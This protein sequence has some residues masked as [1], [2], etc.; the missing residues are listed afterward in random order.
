MITKYRY[1]SRVIAY[2]SHPLNDGMVREVLSGE[3]YPLS[4]LK[5]YCPTV[6]VDIGSNVG[7]SLIYFHEH[8]PQAKIHGFEPSRVNLEFNRKNTALSE[9]GEGGGDLGA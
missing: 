7:A 6:I 4:K 5:G 2:P 1:G 8:F 9:A 3:T